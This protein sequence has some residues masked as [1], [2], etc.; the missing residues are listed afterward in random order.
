MKSTFQ[1]V[2]G[3]GLISIFLLLSHLVFSEEDPRNKIP[4]PDS[5]KMFTVDEKVAKGLGHP[6]QTPLSGRQPTSP[7]EIN[8]RPPLLQPDG[9]LILTPEQVQKVQEEMH[10]QY[11]RV[12]QLRQEDPEKFKAFAAQK[13]KE[14]TPQEAAARMRKALK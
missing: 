3:L 9:D 8:N 2:S 13:K 14:L 5:Q 12:N 4:I 1:R 7:A 11:G 6:Q 10:R